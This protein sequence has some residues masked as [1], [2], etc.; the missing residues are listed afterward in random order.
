MPSS[1]WLPDIV[2]VADYS[3]DMPDFNNPGSSNILNAVPRAASADG[4][5][6]SYGPLM[7]L[8]SYGGGLNLPCQGAAAYLD[9]SDNVNIFAGDAEDLYQ[10][11]SN[12]L[13]P[14]VV[15]NGTHPYNCSST[16]MW[17]FA[18]FGGRVLATDY[19]SPIQSFVLN[20]STTFTPLANGGI[21]SLTLVGGS[22]YTNG[23]YALTVS[24]AGN[25]SGFAGTVT[26]SAGA[27]SSFTITATGK[28]YP[29]TATIAI[30]T[31]AGSGTLGSITPSI[32]TIAPNAMYFAI[33]SNFLMCVNT[34][35][36]VY[37][38]QP[39]CAWWSADN[40]P[41]NWP[42][43]GTANAATYQSS[44]NNLYGEGGQCQGVVGNLGTANGAIFM[45]HAV[46]AVN[47]VG[48]PDVFYFSPCEG[49]RGC[50][51]PGSIVQL[52]S[53]AF[54]LG[55]DGFYRFDGTNSFPIGVNRVDKTFFAQAN[56]SYLGRMSSAVDPVNRMI[57][58]AYCTN[59]AQNGIPNAMLGYS[60]ILD[61][62]TQVS[63]DT[64]P[65]NS[66]VE[67]L[68]RAY[69][70][71][72]TLDTAGSNSIDS[73]AANLFPMDSLV[74]TG[75]TLLFGGFTTTA[76]GNTNHSLGYFN[77]TNY[78]ATMETPER[79]FNPNGRM[80]IDNV[81]PLSDAQVGQISVAVLKRE[82][83]SD[84]VPAIGV[85]SSQYFKAMNS[86]GEAPQIKSGR[87]IRAR[88]SINA[89]ASWSNFMGAKFKGRAGGQY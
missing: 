22:G 32:Q 1:Q 6:T 50:P 59:S 26:V 8:T 74:W 71:G 35:D 27:I 79:E 87:Y 75:G 86:Y 2:S 49:T 85:L 84:T 48:P 62:W 28:F 34:N 81:R 7:R 83:T 53:Y 70:F 73:A 78:A 4:S 12:N 33:I 52:G 47:Y 67:C 66:F 68:F 56:P 15:S 42:V 5:I 16:G 29:Q 18:L 80:N 39:Q 58:W 14:T 21:T 20:S 37:G 31:G 40:D 88:V 36:P 54:Y 57:W 25:G 23:T 77:G 38:P 55:E 82:K 11:T 13:N 45:E 10:Y 17:R 76:D 46:W 72:K 65:G 41:T 69:T 9:S 19:E 89:G 44:F 60:P 51:A 24:N 64:T 3:P 30:P 61:K 43:V 63:D